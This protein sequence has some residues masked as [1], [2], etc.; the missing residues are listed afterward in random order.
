MNEL[1]K[2]L[3]QKKTRRLALPITIIS[4]VI[5]VALGLVFSPLGQ[6]I[7]RVLGE[8]TGGS[9]DSGSDSRIKTIYDSLVT[10]NYGSGSAGSWGNWGSYWNRIRSAAESSTNFQAQSLEEYDDY[11]YGDSHGTGEGGDEESAWSNTAT[12]VWQDERSGLYW[13][14]DLGNFTN[15]FPNQDHSTCDFFSADPRGGYAGGDA[16]CGNAINQCGNLS[17]EAITGEGAET[18][19]YLPSQKELQQAYLDG[20]YNQ[21]AASFA[22][23]SNFWSAT[24][25]SGNSSFAWFVSL[26]NGC[27]YYNAKSNS[28][29]VRCVRRD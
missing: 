17:L 21:T 5:I 3:K 25:A 28:Y 29:A 13:S 22:T 4:L 19:W 9:P 7:G 8:Q 23:S 16:D 24:E 18:D 6:R 10:L 11:E 2:K 14:N 20:M 1:D 12:N 26:H 27:T 15:I